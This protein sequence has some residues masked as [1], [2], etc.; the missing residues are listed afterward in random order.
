VRIARIAALLT[1]ALGLTGCESLA[2][3]VDE[4]LRVGNVDDPAPEQLGLRVG[5][6]E[7]DQARGALTARGHTGVVQDQFAPEGGGLVAV[8]AADYQSRVHVFRDGLYE[9]SILLRTEGVPPYGVALRIARDGPATRLL[10]LYRDPLDRPELPPTLLSFVRRGDRFELASGRPL[11]DVVARNEGLTRPMFVGDDL[12][13]G[14]LLV[15]RNARGTLWDTSYVVRMV[16]GRM[17]LEA[18]PMTDAMRC[19]CVQKYARGI[20]SR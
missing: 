16:E 17:A 1:C 20:T 18:R 4:P 5:V 10:V 2:P 7:L 6:T 19:S 8:L 12:A 14:V 9:G 11:G 13:D 3:A 15:A